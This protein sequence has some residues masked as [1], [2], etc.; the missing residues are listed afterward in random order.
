MSF[1]EIVLDTNM[2]SIYTSF[3]KNW[4]FIAV[5]FL[6]SNFNI[7]KRNNFFTKFTDIINTSWQPSHTSD[8]NLKFSSKQYLYWQR[9]Q[10]HQ[11]LILFN[12]IQD[13]S[14][15]P[16]NQFPSVTSTNVGISPPIFLTFSF[17]PFATLL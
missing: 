16:T 13:G 3:L 5:K 6:F 15:K 7:A 9:I 12:P 14:K 1:S 2:L 11:V 8:W 4:I 10:S 17:N